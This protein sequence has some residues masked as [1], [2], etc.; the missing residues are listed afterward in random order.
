[1]Y[2]RV[3]PAEKSRR[4]RRLLRG[5]GLG[6]VRRPAGANGRRA[7]LLHL[8]GVSRKVLDAASRSGHIPFLSR[9]VNEHAARE[10]SLNAGAP[11]STAAF[12]AGLLY[13]KVRDVPGYLWWDR[14]RRERVRMDVSANVREVEARHEESGPGLLAGGTSYSTLFAGDAT[15]AVFNLGRVR[16]LQWSS[17]FRHWPLSG[18]AAVQCALGAKLW[19]KLALDLPPYLWSAAS[20]S[21]KVGRTDWEGRLLG[22]RLLTSITLRDMATWG[23]IGDISIGVPLVYTCFVEY[24]EVAHRRGP[25]H[26]EALAH[27]R[28]MDRCV[29]SIVAAAAAFPEHGYD[30]YVFSDHG[31]AEST[32]FAKLEGRDLPAFI[33]D[34]AAEIEVIDA[35]DIAHLYFKDERGI[36]PIDAIERRHG[37]VLAALRRSPAIPLIVARSASGP[38][39]LTATQTLRLDDP[40]DRLRLSVHPAFRERDVDLLVSYLR[41]VVT[42]PSGG[43]LVLYGNPGVHGAIAYS[44]EFGSHGGIAHD[45]VESFMLAPPRAPF[46]FEA[47]DFPEELNRWF[48]RYRPPL[49]REQDAVADIA[50]EDPERRDVAWRA[51]ANGD[52]LPDPS[53]TASRSGC[54]GAGHDAHVS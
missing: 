1:M 31:M 49:P 10:W 25:L 32:P 19:A 41:R 14:E 36:V 35:G 47:V 33:D 38:V 27:L 37:A 9:Y 5:I 24:D 46:D 28:A 30:V 29:E 39:A 45:E 6:R 21:A 40:G 7:V 23:T 44:W 4:W 8:D 42:M 48:V 54:D 3:I 18:A 12:Q 17:N 50:A 43:D 22:M 52:A 13:G 20:W 51:L 16:D 26:P 15:P 34:A 2:D 11:A 53:E